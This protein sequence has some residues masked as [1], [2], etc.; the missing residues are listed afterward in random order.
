[1]PFTMRGVIRPPREGTTNRM[2]TAQR[3]D[4]CIR[5]DTRA[6][7]PTEAH[8]GHRAAAAAASLSGCSF[9]PPTHPAKFD[10][11]VVAQHSYIRC[12]CIHAYEALR[13]RVRASLG[14]SAAGVTPEGRRIEP[15]IWTSKRSRIVA[16]LS[17]PSYRL[18][19]ISSFI[20]SSSFLLHPDRQRTKQSV[21]QPGGWAWAYASSSQTTVTGRQLD[22]PTGYG[23][24]GSPHTNG[25]RD[26]PDC[27]IA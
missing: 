21:Y 14:T 4:I 12:G 20:V 1:M 25:Q 10:A 9:S 15:A 18:L 5:N 24:R 23:L 8:D 26:P 22:L 27:V 2:I 13:P 6:Q 11:D 16:P 3:N 19:F 17:A 7:L